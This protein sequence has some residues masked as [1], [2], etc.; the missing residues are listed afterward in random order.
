MCV[1]LTIGCSFSCSCG[2]SELRLSVADNGA[3]C[4]WG[5]PQL[6]LVHAVGRVTCAFLYAP[7][8]V[9]TISGELIF[10]LPLL[11]GV[12]FDQYSYRLP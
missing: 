6:T 11:M 2:A 7:P 4:V 1:Q 9:C 10:S 5:F 12:V 3:S 8:T